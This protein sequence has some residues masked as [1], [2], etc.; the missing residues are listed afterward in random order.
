M[1]VLPKGVSLPE[2]LVADRAEDGRQREHRK[3]V[4]A[5]RLPTL[6]SADSESAMAEI[7]LYCADIVAVKK[8]CSCPSLRNFKKLRCRLKAALCF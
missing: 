7:V 3:Q 4:A 6:F 2:A 5:M 1:V 8:S